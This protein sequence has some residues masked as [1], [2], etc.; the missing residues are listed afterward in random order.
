MLATLELDDGTVTPR[1]QA[2]SLPLHKLQ[3]LEIGRALASKARVVLLDEP[4]AALTSQETE[5]LFGV[6]RRLRS[7]GLSFI[8]VSHRMEEIR[9]IADRMS[10]IRDGKTAVNGVGVDD[11]SDAE[12]L[13]QMFGESL[14]TQHV[15]QVQEQSADLATVI[16]LRVSP[17]PE[18]VGIRRGEVVGLAGAPVGPQ[19]LLNTILGLESQ[20]PWQVELSFDRRAG[21]ARSPRDAITRGIGYVSGDRG[22]KG[23]FPE[24]SIYDNTLVARQ[25]VSR[26][27]FNPP[28]AR[29]EVDKQAVRL[30]F[31]HQDLTQPPSS[32]SGGTQQKFL[33]ARWLNLPVKL[34]LLEE[35]TRGVDLH[36]K[37][38]LYRIVEEIAAAG[39][40]VIWWSTE[41]AELKQTCDRVLAFNV[42]GEPVDVLPMQE[43]DEE[44][45][46]SATGTT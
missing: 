24:L 45:L 41:Y 2:A 39:C 40:A 23:V 42:T 12:V 10:I 44:D 17:S 11:I 21:S 14:P 22:D 35:P 19:G 25:V 33:L 37:T 7:D 20:S 18:Q 30:G 31:A 13:T 38:D 5:V 1:T 29:R 3:L 36:T 6:L 15:K 32:L 4:T 16:E 34:L 8:F 43:I 27:V 46:L 26:S 9:Q 28:A